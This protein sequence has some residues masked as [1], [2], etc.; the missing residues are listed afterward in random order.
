MNC[1]I[2]GSV[3]PV[4]NNQLMIRRVPRFELFDE[5][6]E[7]RRDRSRERVVLVPQSFPDFCERSPPLA[8][9][10]DF[11]L[12]G[13]RNDVPTYPVVDPVSCGDK[14]GHGRSPTSL[15][16]LFRADALLERGALDLA[17][18]VKHLKP[19]TSFGDQIAANTASKCHQ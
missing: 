2:S 6:N 13:I 7:L 19:N 17:A 15:R 8:G 12:R 9:R 4:T 18:V 3:P 5:Y 11:A 16:L 1:R 10:I 14:V